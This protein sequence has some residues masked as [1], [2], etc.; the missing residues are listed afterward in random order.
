M[1]GH[2]A[3]ENS[4]RWTLDTVFHDG[5]RRNRKGHGAINMAIVRH[6]AFNPVRSLNHKRSLKN[7]RKQAGWD[8]KYLSV[9]P[10]AL[11]C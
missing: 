4:P 8:T 7:R 5:P 6:G 10:G 2:R 9:I 11:P 3:I 1:R